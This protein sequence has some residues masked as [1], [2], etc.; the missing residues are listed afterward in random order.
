M[1]PWKRAKLGQGRIGRGPDKGREERRVECV[2]LMRG[3]SVV[4][5]VVGGD[6]ACFH[7]WNGGDG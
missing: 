5:V 7:L 1:F 3:G 4:V 2:G 6:V